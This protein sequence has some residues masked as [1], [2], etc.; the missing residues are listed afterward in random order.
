MA[1]RLHLLTAGYCTQLERVSRRGGG[2]R[3]ITFPSAVGVIRHP[4]R[5]VILFDAGYAPRF[6]TETAR[7][8]NALYRHAL[9]V[10]CAP[11]DAAAAQLRAAGIDPA[12]VAMVVV[13]HFHADHIA[14]LR[15]F[16]N[17]RFVYSR[18][19]LNPAW[20][21]RSAWVSVR[22]GLIR[23]LLPDDLEQRSD[24]VETKPGFGSPVGEGVDLLGDGSL[25]A[26]HLGGHTHGHLGLLV[27]VTQGPPV[28]LAGDAVWT[29]RA[30]T[31]GELPHPVVRL[32]TADWP[33][34]RD[35]IGALTALHR[36]RPDL[37]IV[38]SHCV[39]SLE[40]AQ[41]ELGAL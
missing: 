3:P 1:V 6:F 8:P 31:H 23:G 2:W 37:L 21:Q 16:P 7:W 14:G 19:A 33:G 32:V 41:A 38:P 25:V 11:E 12:E 17:A 18:H 5:G 9:P 10:T 28:L 29:H 22:H 15:D 27:E 34:Y 36:D 39:P 35:R 13:S 20:R 24:V 30:F 26:V 4:S 40:R